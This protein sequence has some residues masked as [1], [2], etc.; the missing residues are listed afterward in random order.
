MVL[1][2]PLRDP[3]A[4]EGLHQLTWYSRLVQD[5]WGFQGKLRFAPNRKIHFYFG[6]PECSEMHEF[7]LFLKGS[8][9]RFYFGR[10]SRDSSGTQALAMLYERPEADLTEILGKRKNQ[11]F[12]SSTDSSSCPSFDTGNGIR[13][14]E[15]GKL[16]GERLR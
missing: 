15:R 11:C 2:W 8:W 10:M 6:R 1:Q 16:T 3:G 4:S 14:T 12:H 7:P 9:G 13:V 5:V